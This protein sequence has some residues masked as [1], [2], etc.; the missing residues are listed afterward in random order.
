MTVETCACSGL[1][2]SKKRVNSEGAKLC[3]CRIISIFTTKTR[4]QPDPELQLRK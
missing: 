4:A 2:A 1:L 3:Y